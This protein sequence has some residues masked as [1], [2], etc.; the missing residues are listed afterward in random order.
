MALGRVLRTRMDQTLDAEMAAARA[1]VRRRRS[2]RDRLLEAEDSGAIVTLV[3]G[4]GAAHRGS[5]AA[6]GVDHIDL[7]RGHTVIT[8]AIEHIAVIEVCS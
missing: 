1:A 6:V 7:V 4:D 5:I 3:V 2:L 8:V